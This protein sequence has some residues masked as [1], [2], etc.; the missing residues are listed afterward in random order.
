M[1]KPL[2]LGINNAGPVLIV[3]LG[4]IIFS[5]IVVAATIVVCVG[6]RFVKWLCGIGKR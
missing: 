3:F 2:F 6:Y 5:V 4:I 1:Y